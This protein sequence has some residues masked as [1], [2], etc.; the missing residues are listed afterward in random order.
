MVLSELLKQSTKTLHQ[1]A[2]STF[3]IKKLLKGDLLISDY[4]RYLCELYH[5]YFTLEQQLEKFKNDYRLGV[6]SNKLLYRS[7]SILVD[8]DSFGISCSNISDSCKEYASAIK[9]SSD[10]NSITLLSH[11]YVRYFGDLNG[12]MIISKILKKNYKLNQTNLNFYDFSCLI[13]QVSDP[14]KKMKQSLDA[15]NFKEEEINIIL[16]TAK[17]AFKY[18]IKLLEE[19]L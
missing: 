2:E 16:N 6:F 9:N 13:S 8:L 3:F 12:G 11:A 18:N 5:I 19:L 17:E 4:C 14:T 7:K 10:E 15:L 1:K